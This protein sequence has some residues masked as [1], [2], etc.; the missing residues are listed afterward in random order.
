MIQPDYF[1]ICS[2]EN[3][4][5]HAHH[6]ATLLGRKAIHVDIPSTQHAALAI[7]GAAQKR[8]LHAG[9]NQPSSCCHTLPRHAAVR[10]SL[11]GCGDCRATM[12]SKGARDCVLASQDFELA[13]H[14]Y[15]TA[16]SNDEC[17]YMQL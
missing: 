11:H 6:C 1:V 7:C 13:L 12:R 16:S 17:C 10:A 9:Q 5:L 8:S 3:P 4:C 15:A 14:I 2:R